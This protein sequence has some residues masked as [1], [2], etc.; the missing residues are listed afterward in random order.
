MLAGKKTYIVAAVAVITALG[1][2]LTGDATLA[3]ALNQALLGA[4]LATLRIGIASS[5]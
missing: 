1:A 5:K 3:E 2:F 4:G